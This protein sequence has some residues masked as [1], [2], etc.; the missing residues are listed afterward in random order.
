[1]KISSRYTSPGVPFFIPFTETVPTVQDIHTALQSLVPDTLAEPWDNVGILVGSPAQPVHRILVALDPYTALAEQAVKRNCDLIITHHPIIFR[2]I[3]ALHTNT[4]VGAFLAAV[5]RAGISVIAC[6]T[7]LDSMAKGVS[8]ALAQ[9]LGLEDIRPLVPST[10]SCADQCG[11]GSIGTYPHPL[12]ATELIQRLQRF[13]APEWLLDAGNRPE[14]I[15][16][17]AVCGG[18]G[19]DLAETALAQ[20]AEVY[21]TAEIKHNVARWAEEVGIWLVDA[22]HFPTENP[23]MPLF[24]QHLHDLLHS[25]TWTIPIELAEQEAPLRLLWS[26]TGS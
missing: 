23:A 13:C 3:K 4:P 12:P 9:G 24:V 20:G 7:N 1:M 8:N 19:S 6:H 14:S 16:R 17:V 26:P 18:S 10:H 2:P 11:L 21:I 25:R 22:G 15:S 5:I